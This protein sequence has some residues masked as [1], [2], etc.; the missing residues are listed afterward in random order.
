MVG[1]G[2]KQEKGELYTW[3]GGGAHFNKGQCGHGHFND[4]EKPDMVVGL[5]EKHVLDVSCGGYHT[6]C[7]VEENE[8]TNSV[9]SWGSGYY[10]QLGNGETVDTHSPVQM[11]VKQKSNDSGPSRHFDSY[12]GIKI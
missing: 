1:I 12:E 8:T 4:S 3:G 2:N 5:K 10:G 9:Y 7:I 6:V 11:I